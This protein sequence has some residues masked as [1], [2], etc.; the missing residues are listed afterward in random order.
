MTYTEGSRARLVMSFEACELSDLARALVPID[1]GSTALADATQV[2]AAAH[3]LLD[4]AVV[5]RRAAG[6]SWQHIGDVLGLPAAEA[7][8]R[9]S[10][11]EARF[12]QQLC[13]P[14]AADGGGWRDHIVREPR[15][16]AED[17][18]EWVGHGPAPV[19][20]GLRRGDD[21]PAGSSG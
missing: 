3:R 21:P 20:G 13:S 10:P 9:F 15:E 16:A 5:A 1:D 19:S 14:N 8:D 6:R 17:L 18:D 7:Q 2:L 11:A 12:R 4:A